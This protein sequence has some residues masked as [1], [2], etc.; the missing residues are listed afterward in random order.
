MKDTNPAIEEMFCNMMMARSGEEKLRMG[1]EMYEMA[2]KIVIASILKDNPGISERD[3]KISLFNRFYGND[4]S[5]ETRKMFI[6]GIT[7]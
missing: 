5:P 1:F 2:R 3:M 7:E 6:E 4:L